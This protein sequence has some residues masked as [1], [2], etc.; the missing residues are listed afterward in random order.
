MNEVQLVVLY[1][2][3]IGVN[4]IPSGHLYAKTMADGVDLDKHT[5]LVGV[6]KHVGW[7]EERAFFLTL[8]EKGLAKH[9]EVAKV[10]LEGKR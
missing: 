4:G 2:V 7:V 1:L 8:T 3:A 5:K 6:L 10:L 9:A